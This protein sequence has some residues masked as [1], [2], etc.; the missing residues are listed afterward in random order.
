M[1]PPGQVCQVTDDRAHGD[2]RR[3]GVKWTQAFSRNCRNQSLRCEGRS[4]SGENHEA[5]VPMRSTGA[6]CSVLAMNRG[7]ARGAKGAG[8][9]RRDRWVNRQLEEPGGFGGRQQ[10][11]LSGTS[12]M[13]RECHV[14]ICEGLGA[15]LLGST[16]LVHRCE[17]HRAVVR[18]FD[19][20]CFHMFPPIANLY[21]ASFAERRRSS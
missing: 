20:R 16:R 10:P 13:T 6:D 15:Q 9:S 5:R 19:D 4:T 18:F 17:S 12:R 21:T 14:R 8:H 1:V 11:S 7:N 2:R 3:G